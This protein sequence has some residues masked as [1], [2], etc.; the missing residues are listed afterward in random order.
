MEV[1]S[2]FRVSCFS[3]VQRSEVQTWLGV[4]GP[5]VGP[6]AQKLIKMESQA[7]S[8]VRVQTQAEVGSEV[9]GQD[10]PSYLLEMSWGRTSA[11]EV[12]MIS[13]QG[14]QMTMKRPGSRGGVQATLGMRASVLVSG[15]WALTA[16]ASI[17]I[18]LQGHCLFSPSRLWARVGVE[19]VTQ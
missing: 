5:R 11:R 13:F 8:W 15:T 18:M 4:R 17:S 1:R 12:P 10:Q 16:L 2:K 14:L 9:K 19:E 6:I 7:Q 3:L